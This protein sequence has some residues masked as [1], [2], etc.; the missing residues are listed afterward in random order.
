VAAGLAVSVLGAGAALALGVVDLRRSRAE[1]AAERAEADDG[2]H[3]HAHAW[4]H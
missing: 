1:E 2:A 3:R 4:H